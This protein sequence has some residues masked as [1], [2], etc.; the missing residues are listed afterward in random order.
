MT[1]STAYAA[2]PPAWLLELD[3]THPAS[4]FVGQTWA[5][6]DPALL[7]EHTGIPDDAPGEGTIHGIGAAFPH[8]VHDTEE[9]LHTPFADELV[10]DT[11]EAALEPLQLGIDDVPDLLAISFDAHDY[12]GHNWG[13]GSWESLDLTLRLDA[14]LG[15]LF[16][17][18]DRRVGK[19]RWAV[20]LTSDHGATPLVERSVVP[21]ARRLVPAE[22]AAAGGP[23]VQKVSSNEVYMTRGWAALSQAERRTTLAST[24]AAIRAGFPD[25]DV[26]DASDTTRCADRGL[27]GDVC[28]AIV[29]GASGELYLA[30]HRGFV[31]TDYTSG[32]HHDAPNADN[33]E[34]PILVR[35]PGLAPQTIDRASLLQVA[36]TLAALLG[37]PP[38][39]SATASPLFGIAAR[40]PA[41][42]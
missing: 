12:A 17:T 21:G 20:V 30:P 28:R 24:A 10:M 16:D 19:D 40:S 5:A 14:A 13:P 33:Q 15:E 4:R 26:F 27:A 35:A 38:P 8:V 34:V 42:P 36:P 25:V 29:P 7:A 18:L 31:I 22:I 39:A 9:L 11:V 23:L 37:I 32:T 3:R 1:T 2:T 6:H 41:R